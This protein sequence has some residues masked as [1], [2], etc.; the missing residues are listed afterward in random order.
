MQGF[1]LGEWYPSLEEYQDGAWWETPTCG[2]MGVDGE[3]DI[4]EPLAYL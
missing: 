3:Q 2:W 1:D 4:G